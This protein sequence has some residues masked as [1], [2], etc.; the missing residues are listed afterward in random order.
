MATKFSKWPQNFSIGHKID[1]LAIKY[2][3][4]LR[5]LQNTLKFTQIWIFGLKICHLATLATCASKSLL[6]FQTTDNAD[7]LS[8][9]K[10]NFCYAIHGE[11]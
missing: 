5:S 2:A 11:T 9:F 6:T 8:T 4:Q 1:K 10:P 7:G 3:N